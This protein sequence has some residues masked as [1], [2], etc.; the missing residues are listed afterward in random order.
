M[1][2][3]GS[4][5]LLV[6]V[7]AAGPRAVGQEQE[8]KKPAP[9]ALTVVAP[10]EDGTNI[11]A[12]NGRGDVVGFEWVESAERPG[13][14]EQV[15]FFAHGK[16][17]T[18]LPKLEGYTATS[19]AGVS[20]DGRV[21]GRASKPAPPD[22]P[23][24]LRN[25]A[26]VWEAD[27]GIRALG[28]LPGDNASFATAISR[29]GRRIA[30]VS[31]GDGRI[32]ACIWDLGDDGV[33]RPSALPQAAAVGPTVVLSPDGRLAAAVDGA[34]PS[35]WTRG[36]AGDW[37]RE[38]IGGPGSLAPRAVNDAGT[39]VGV[40]FEGDGTTRAVLW[41]R[42]GGLKTIPLPPGHV[43]AEAAAINGAGLVVGMA[44]GPGGSDIGPS[45]FAFDG[46]AVRIIKE[47]G[48]GFTAAAAINDRG[49]VAGVV[50]KVE[51]PP[52]APRPGP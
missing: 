28:T 16:V 8:D 1:R 21:V 3:A 12:I 32:R 42:A 46:Q 6:L 35:L 31:V 33:W 40:R 20:D 36:A 2:R 9:G 7:A 48:P 23:V 39:V 4:L 15:P 22:V 51:V 44:D 5:L 43:K 45:A 41:S 26:F 27:R 19:P 47:G 37:S 30:G 34:S 49:Q 18:Y 14:V 11:V 25:Q 10:K 17:M 38:A 29:D 13:V 24:P 52:P 50:E